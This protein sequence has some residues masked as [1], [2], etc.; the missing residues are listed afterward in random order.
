MR[1]NLKDSFE[2]TISEKTKCDLFVKYLIRNSCSENLYFFLD[3]R[4]YETQP[5]TEDRKSLA[6]EIYRDYINWKT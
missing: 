1:S 4:R 5:V 3:V 6:E 2:E